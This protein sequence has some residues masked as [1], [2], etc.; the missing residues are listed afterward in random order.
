MLDCIYT[1]QLGISNWQTRS[2][3]WWPGLSA[4]IENIVKN[5]STCTKD[6]PELLPFNSTGGASCWLL[7]TCSKLSL[8]E[9][10]LWINCDATASFPRY[11]VWTTSKEI[12][13]WWPVTTQ[14]WVV[15]LFGSIFPTRHDQSE[16]LPTSADLGS[17]TSSVWNL[18]AR[19]SDVILWGASGNLVKSSASAVWPGY[20]AIRL[21]ITECGFAQVTKKSAYSSFGKM[22]FSCQE[23]TAKKKRK[24]EK[25]MSCCAC[26]VLKV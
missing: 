5:C 4:Q 1:G 22:T 16:A 9:T 26:F 14:I 23:C 7:W 20:D 2:S 13:Y 25:T 8:I 11:N 10:K 18:F 15:L 24:K 12:P 21:F 6:R 17:V 3:V 19:V